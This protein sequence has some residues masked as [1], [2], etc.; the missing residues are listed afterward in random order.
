MH[1]AIENLKKRGF[2]QQCSNAEGLSKLMDEGPVTPE[3]AIAAMTRV[4]LFCAPLFT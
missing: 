2:F 1:P 3:A 4:R